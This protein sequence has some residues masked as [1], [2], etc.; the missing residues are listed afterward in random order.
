MKQK[1]WK[2]LIPA[3]L[4]C[5]C[6]RGLDFGYQ[7]PQTPYEVGHGMIELGEQL[8]DPYSLDNVTKALASL[9]P[10]KSVSLTATDRYVRFLPKNEAEYDKLGDMG[11]ILIDHPLD[12]R[13]VKDG[14]YY[15]DPS[16]GEDRITWQYAV[17]SPSFQFPKEIEYEILDECYIPENDESTKAGG[18]IDWTAVEAE[19]YRITGNGDMVRTDTK[20]GP[21]AS[22]P[23]GTIQIVDEKYNGGKPTGVKGV[24]ISV[25]SFV[26]FASAYTD[27][28]G[29]YQIDR[30]FSSNIRYRMVF[31]NVKGF[32]IGFNLLLIPA[33]I[34]ALGSD[35]PEGVSIVIDRNSDRKQFARSVVNNAAY[36]YYSM[37]EDSDISVRTPPSNLRFW[38]FQNIGIA[39]SPMFQQGAIIDSDMVKSILGIYG[40]ILKTFMPDVL[41]GLDGCDDYSS[42]Y[43][44]ALHQLAHASHYMQVGNDFWNRLIVFNL[45]AFIKSGFVAYGAG[46]E[47]DAGYCEVGEMWAYFIQNSLYRDRYGNETPSFGTNYWFHPQ[48]FLYLA[49][50]GVTRGKIY[51]S[52]TPEAVSGAVLRENMVNLYPENR[53]VIE[54]AFD[55]YSY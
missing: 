9:Y 54:Q 55:R 13:I 19:A 22:G 23:C 20:G 33:S 3:V 53:S 7:E 24:R 51:K 16:V 32:G 41:L 37:T 6:N 39:C 50:R 46:T 30:S 26:K 40:D 31:Q 21:V 28:D 38:L 2:L 1:F 10:T 8:E 29:H 27:E 5:A 25:N 12:Y 47:E 14:D 34:S 36:D 4:L 11:V 43:A 17:V 44:A 48:I 15:H 45:K 52:L 35:T 18:D 42:I 49:E